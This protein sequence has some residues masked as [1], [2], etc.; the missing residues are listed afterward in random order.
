MRKQKFLMWFVAVVLALGLAGCVRELP[1]GEPTVPLAPPVQATLPAALPGAE[2]AP[3]PGAEQAPSTPTPA[4]QI[5]LP[6]ISGEGAEGEA[7][8]Q[9]AGGTNIYFPVVPADVLAPT[10]VDTSQPAAGSGAET[11]LGE[12]NPHVQLAVS[13]AQLQVGQ[14]V[15]IVATPVDIGLPY[16]YLYAQ[17]EG[18]AAPVELVRVTDSNEVRQSQSASAILRLVEATGA[19]DSGTFVL[20]AVAP[21]VTVLWVSATGE[22]HYPEGAVWSGGSSESARITVSN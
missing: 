19:M 5:H 22:V 2:T 15:T 16:Y 11:S 6:A 1:G 10:P 18:S 14:T 20:E 17:D 13:S 8:G 7:G 12:V 3:V 9:Q 4:E 21:G